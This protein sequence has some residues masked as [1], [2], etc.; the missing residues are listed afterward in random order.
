MF[1][2][3]S[4]LTAR[5]PNA[6]PQRV[7]LLGTPST[8]RAMRRTLR[9]ADQPMRFIGAILL[10]RQHKSGAIGMPVLGTVDQ[11]DMIV[12]V[13]QVERVLLSLPGLMRQTRDR[14]MSRL[15][16]LG[17]QSQHLPTLDD[18]LNG[19][20]TGG[21]TGSPVDVSRLLNRP[22]HQ[23]DEQAIA[24]T[25]AGK[26][27]MI[28]GAG[29]SIGSEL[30]RLIG[31]YAPARLIL[32]ERAENNLFEIQRNLRDL[33]PQVPIQPVL[34]DVVHAQRTAELCQEHQP[35][36]IFHAA[37]HKH[38]PM[39]ED[40]PR[41]AVS[42]NFFGTR[43]IAD[44][45]A[46]CGAERFV[47]ISTD[48]AVNPTSV[49][50]ATKRMAELYVQHMDSQ[51]QTVFTMVRF[52]NVLG[53]ACS[54]IP[55]WSSQLINGGPITVTDP[56][57]TRYFMTIPEAAALVLQAG[58]LPDVGGQVLLLDM[59]RPIRI[60]DLAERFIRLQGLE[61]H[62]DVPIVFTGARPGEKLFEELAYDSEDMIPTT[63][64]AVRIWRTQPSQPHRIEKMI[65]QFGQLRDTGQPMQILEALRQAVPEMK[66]LTT[67][68]A[69]SEQS[70]TRS[71]SKSA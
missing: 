45:A 53:S 19:R 17:V 32:M 3:S 68:A 31:R 56:A 38:V 20:I 43:A 60:V 54:V 13:H 36:V 1:W 21:G 44:A 67:A 22:A 28:T 62:T 64:A 12:Q 57:M 51:H 48:K 39:M 26:R 2:F 7:A 23:L 70:A 35:Q 29:G 41:E 9:G 10:H 5:Q 25:L 47:M 46:A 49:M 61:P 37:A 16:E 33:V 11:L 42:N 65:R 69:P 30:A 50:G 6:R 58:C 59:G 27:V 24:A 66:P 18:Q 40:H 14:L 63:H 8:L 55:I 71:L 34:H 15:D 52:G 4:W